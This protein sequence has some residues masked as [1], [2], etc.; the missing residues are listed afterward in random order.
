MRNHAGFVAIGVDARRW[1]GRRW[2]GRRW[3]GAIRWLYWQASVRV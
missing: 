3:L 2:L 1:R